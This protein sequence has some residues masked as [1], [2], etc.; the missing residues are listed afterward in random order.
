LHK[1]PLRWVSTRATD[2]RVRIEPGVS[3]EIAPLFEEPGPKEWFPLYDYEYVRWQLETCPVVSCW[4]GYIPAQ[5][6]PRAAAMIW[7]SA[8]STDFW[9]LALWGVRTAPE[10][11]ELLVKRMAQ[12]AYQQNGAAVFAVASH[13][14][15]E[16]LQL[17]SAQGFLRRRNRLP[18]YAVRGRDANLA[19]DEFGAMSFLDADMAY[20]F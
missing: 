20:R 16:L 11:A 8:S 14:D 3:A 19:F 18:F 13:L 7:R 6:A 17:L 1:I 15:R 9:R 10:E 12:F 5:P 4:S 2:E